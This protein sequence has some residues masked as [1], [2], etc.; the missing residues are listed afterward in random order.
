MDP[1][2]S[3]VVRVARPVEVDVIG[4]ERLE[5]GGELP[6]DL[7]GRPQ[8]GALEVALVAVAELGGEEFLLAPCLRC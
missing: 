1:F 8:L 2:G 4:S 3:D 6:E 5:G 7:V